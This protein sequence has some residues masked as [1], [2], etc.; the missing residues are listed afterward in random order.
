MIYSLLAVVHIRRQSPNSIV[1]YVLRTFNRIT[2]MWQT[3]STRIRFIKSHIVCVL[4][5]NIIVRMFVKNLFK[6][7]LWQIILNEEKIPLLYITTTKSTPYYIVKRDYIDF[8]KCIDFI[9]PK[10][11]YHYTYK[12]ATEKKKK[13]TKYIICSN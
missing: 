3:I 8:L 6:E 4:L 2:Y 12:T 5:S 11:Y 9:I 1:R 10:P 7:F 13:K